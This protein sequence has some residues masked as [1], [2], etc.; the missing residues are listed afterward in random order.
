M[1][2]GRKK[3]QLFLK[4][5]FQLTNVEEKKER[6][7]HLNNCCRQDRSISWQ[8]SIFMHTAQVLHTSLCLV[9][10]LILSKNKESAKGYV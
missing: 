3:E 1:G 6:E 5:E 4:A 8:L 7:N 10:K 2:G 9:I